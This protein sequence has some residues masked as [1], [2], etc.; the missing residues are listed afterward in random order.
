MPI[1]SVEINCQK[2]PVRLAPGEE[3]I[4]YAIAVDGILR[5]T[6]LGPSIAVYVHFKTVAYQPTHALYL[7]LIG[8]NTERKFSTM[9]RLGPTHQAL[10]WFPW[11][12][13]TRY[14]TI[15]ES[16]GAI[17]QRSHSGKASDTVVS[18]YIPPSPESAAEIAAYL[19]QNTLPTQVYG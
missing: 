19:S 11:D 18:K 13:L 3:G 15:F 4:P 14:R 8:P 12:S 2:T 16:E 5:N 9:F 10:D 17:A 7:G 1:V 6:G